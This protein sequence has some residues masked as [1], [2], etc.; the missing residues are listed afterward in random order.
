MKPNPVKA[1]AKITCLSLILSF[2]SFHLLAQAENNLSANLVQ[3]PSFET[4]NDGLALNLRNVINRAQHWS[5][6]TAG[7]S[8][9]YTTSDQQM[10]VGTTLPENTFKVP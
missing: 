5:D 3:N 6:P 10:A 8:L 4:S 7:G 1:L 9:L 2:V